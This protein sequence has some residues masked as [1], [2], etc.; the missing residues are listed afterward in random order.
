MIRGKKRLLDN[1]S[2]YVYDDVFVV[3]VAIKVVVVVVVVVVVPLV[4]GVDVV[5]CSTIPVSTL[6]WVKL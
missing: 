3:T 6:G 5:E 4:L 1:F 2:V